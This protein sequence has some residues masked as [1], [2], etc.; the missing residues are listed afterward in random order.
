MRLWAQVWPT[1]EKR[2][3]P[4]VE[5]LAGGFT[6]GMPGCEVTDGVPGCEVKRDAGWLA[7]WRYQVRVAASANHLGYVLSSPVH[8]HCLG[9][10]FATLVS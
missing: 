9:T 5:G 3:P 4:E 10:G 7:L 2:L 6:D 1:E 8:C